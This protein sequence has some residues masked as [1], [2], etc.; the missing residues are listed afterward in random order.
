[1]GKGRVEGN[2]NKSRAN[3]G[4]SKYLPI[5]DYEVDKLHSDVYM[6]KCPSFLI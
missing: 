5:D 6:S 2:K 4:Q 1:M 3:S